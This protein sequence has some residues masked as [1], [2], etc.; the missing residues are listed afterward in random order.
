MSLSE[1]SPPEDKALPTVERIKL[2][3]GRLGQAVSAAIRYSKVG[4]SQFE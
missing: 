1:A 4:R 2:R 3:A